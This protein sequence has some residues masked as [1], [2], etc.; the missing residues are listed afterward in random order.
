MS[1]LENEIT[2]ID[3][4]LS[5][6]VNGLGHVIHIK[7]YLLIMLNR[8]KQEQN[9][10]YMLFLSNIYQPLYNDTCSQKETSSLCQS[11]NLM[12]PH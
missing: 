4:P 11:S 10:V 6:M 9:R 12:F 3:L 1:F 8:T 5:F 7:L 2:I